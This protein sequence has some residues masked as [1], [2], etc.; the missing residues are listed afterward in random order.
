MPDAACH[1]CTRPATEECPTCGRLYC[2]E[3]GEDVCLRCLSPEAATPNAAV[4][5]GALV[6]LVVGTLLTVF[7]LVRPPESKSGQDSVRTLA[8]PTPSFGTTATPTPR[9]TAPPQSPTAGPGTPAA[10]TTP[11]PTGGATAS[12]TPGS[13]TVQAGDTLSGIAVA[14][15]ITVEQL[16]AA[17][18]GLTEVIQIGQVLV[19]PPAR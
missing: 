6:A 13:Y 17:N 12:P 2:T 8:T 3:H 9:S 7:L 19:L 15:G 10:A 5:R 11:S 1:Y 16:Q 18:P 14:N 4:Y